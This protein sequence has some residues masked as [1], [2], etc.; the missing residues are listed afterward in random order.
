MN[1]RPKVDP[2]LCNHPPT[3]LYVWWARDDRAPGGR[4]LCVACYD[5]GKVLNGG[6]R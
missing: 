2:D 5:C 1:T 6:V 4:V 3:R